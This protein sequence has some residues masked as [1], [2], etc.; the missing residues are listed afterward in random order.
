[1]NSR[2][3]DLGNKNTCVY[4]KNPD[5]ETNSNGR[6]L[7]QI[8]NKFN[9]RTLN[10]LSIHGKV[11]DGDF[12][13][14]KDNRRSQVDL[15]LSNDRAL[16]SVEA[17]HI[18]KLPINFSD[19]APISA[20]LLFDINSSIPTNYIT[21]D[22]LSN[23]EDDTGRKPRKIPT[24]IN[25]DAYVNTASRDLHDLK[26]RMDSIEEYTQ[27][28]VDDIVSNLGTIISNSAYAHK[29]ELI[30]SD[31][32]PEL[33]EANRTIQEIS[34]NISSKEIKSWN[35]ILNNKNSKELWSKIN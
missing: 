16:H 4:K 20:E 3:G 31:F 33:H 26:E 24:N 1:M 13:Y 28:T 5:S 7:K 22:L 8:C 21:S 12:T 35:D 34:N 18:H 10:N 27:D 19:H 23:N 14:C 32:T 30:E 2:V 11:L 6:S 9:I 17:F 25:W 15:C 29:H